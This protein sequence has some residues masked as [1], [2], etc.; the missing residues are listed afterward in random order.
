MEQWKERDPKHK[1]YLI[2]EGKLPPSLF[3]T[4]PPTSRTSLKFVKSCNRT[5]R[6][7][8][9]GSTW[10]GTDCPTQQLLCVCQCEHDCRTHRQQALRSLSSAAQFR[11]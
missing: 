4:C 9:T 2:Y 1:S 5:V 6:N 7:P 10:I 3:V 11:L 8:G